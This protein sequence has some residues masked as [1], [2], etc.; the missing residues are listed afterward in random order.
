MTSAAEAQQLLREGRLL[1]AELAFERVLEGSPDHVEALNVLA[2][3]ALRKGQLQSAVQM[4]S[5]AARAD[6]HDAATQHHLGRAHDAAGDLQNAVLAHAAAVKLRPEFHVGR[7][8]WA[9]SLELAGQ[10]DLAVVQYVRALQDAQRQ[11]RWLNPDTTPKALQ[12]L[13]EHAVLTVRERRNEAF[14]RIFEPLRRTYGADSLG[15]V[16][17][18]LRIHLNQEAPTYSD[19]RQRPSF[20]FMPQLPPSA[21]LDR[22]LFDWIPALEAQTAAIR[23][24]LL[25]LLPFE[26]GRER[27]F[28][29]DELEQ[30]NLRGAEFAPSWNGYYFYRHGVRREDNC[31]SCPAT[32]LALDALPLSRVRDHGPEVLFSVFT[33]GTHLLPHRGVTNTRLVGHLPLLVPPDCALSVGGEVHAWVPGEVVIFDDTYEHEAWNRSREI[34]VVMIFD[35]WNPYLTQ[36]E[37]AALSDLVPAIGEFREAV[38][39]G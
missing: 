8:Y 10:I 22:S 32:I 4:L 9:A 1:E 35:I 38:E 24:E 7:L 2:L 29:S 23:A 37:R 18:A 15:R 6:P 16:E 11:G 39:Q 5:R 20:L 30:A 28:T 36:A 26:A 31:A 25:Q 14:A 27:V 13:I 17:Q 34:R 12:G 3:G 33:P 21:Y 19:P